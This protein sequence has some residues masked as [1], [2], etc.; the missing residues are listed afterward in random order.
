M[1]YMKIIFLAG[2]LLVSTFLSS[3]LKEETIK[4]KNEGF[5]P[6]EL[7][8][9]WHIST[10]EAENMDRKKLQ[11]AYDFIYKENRYVMA[12]SLL[13]FRNGKLVAEAYP[14]NRQDVEKFNNIQSCTKSI[15][16]LLVGVAMQQNIFTSENEKLYDIYPEY[17]DNDIVK[18]DITIFDALCMRS[19]IDFQN[20]KHTLKLYSTHQ[21]STEYVL[22]LGRKSIPGTSVLYNDGDP[23]LISKAI[24]KRSGMSLA[25]FAR[26]HV[27]EKLNIKTW[28]WEHARD[29]TTFGA[30]SLFL[31]A[32]DLGKIGQ[33]V[34][35]NGAWNNEQIVD[36]VFLQQAVSTQ[37]LSNFDNRPY[38]YYFWIYPQ[39]EA[40]AAL[41]HGGQFL[42]IAPARNLII[43]YTAWPYTGSSLWDDSEALMGLIFDSCE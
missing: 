28:Q 30:F 22:S 34:L 26:V 11:Q 39:W 29:G 7:N 8:D 25:E 6:V 35:Q 38:G 32:R 2:I 18:R 37:V 42:F 13:V 19:G 23:H 40:F 41:G 15:T 4:L 31:T 16:S 33:L 20:D 17:F 1:D 27:F 12:K 36:S 5:S 43:A 10:P 3:C 21:N 24:E 9:G 14:N